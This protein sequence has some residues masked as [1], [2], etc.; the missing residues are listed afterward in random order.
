MAQP[1]ERD[2]RGDQIRVQRPNAKHILVRP[3]PTANTVDKRKHDLEI[4]VQIGLDCVQL[5]ELNADDQ[6]RGE[7]CR[8]EIPGVR[9]MLAA[10]EP[11]PA[12]SSAQAA[13][14]RRLLMLGSVRPWFTG[15]HSRRTQ[16]RIATR[17]THVSTNIKDNRCGTCRAAPSL[18]RGLF[19]C[20]SM[21]AFLTQNKRAGN[22]CRPV[23]VSGSPTRART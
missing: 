6:Q 10:V 3:V 16:I 19:G 2:D 15:H 23:C 18:H 11:R 22:D 8:N 13:F 7:Q 17:R 1:G 14:R 9:T 4:A 20:Q 5:E 12:S 21:A